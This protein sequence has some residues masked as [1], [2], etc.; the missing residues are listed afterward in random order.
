MKKLLIVLLLACAT[1]AAAQRRECYGLL[2]D[3]DLA[4]SYGEQQ[5]KCAKGAAV[6]A[7]VVVVIEGKE[8][9]MTYAEFEKRIT[10][11]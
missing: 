9:R 2:V 5:A 8:Y 1:I 11:K 10:A 6:V 4:K 7:D 3:I